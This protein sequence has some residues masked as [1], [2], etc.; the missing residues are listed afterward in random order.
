[1][2]QPAPN[3]G[4]RNNSYFESPTPFLVIRSAA[5]WLA[6]EALWNLHQ[7]RRAETLA[8]IQG[9]A[10]LADLHREEYALVSQM[11]RAA[12]ADL[13]LNLT[14]E[15]LQT[16]EWSDEQ[17]LGLQTCWEGK[18]FLETAEKA[19]V[20]ERLLSRETIKIKMSQEKD[21]S[22]R[23]FFSRFSNSYYGTNLLDADLLF[24]LRHVQGY[25]EQVRALRTNRAWNEVSDSLDQLN[26]RIDALTNSLQ[27]IRY[28][29][30][31]IAT[32]NFKPAVRKGVQ[33]ET[34]RRI[35]ITAIA[36]N[37]YEHK[38][39][40]YPASLD[41]LVPGLLPAIPRDCMN[42][43]PLGYQFK[44]MDAFILYSVGEDG[45]DNSGDPNPATN[46]GGKPGLWA[47]RD[48]VWPLPEN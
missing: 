20:G 39:G 33:T 4:Y 1:M 8:S 41:G 48:A 21:P 34:Q 40:Q 30:T 6:S 18:D 44:G 24:R 7:G 15:A 16:K 46:L 37:R 36:L 47:G 27:R 26:A 28:P 25:V 23:E 14:W 42:G 19:M 5:N 3:A 17:L 45:Q 2:K 43:Q 38:H 13:G 32:P 11:S 29:L 10:G 9:L 12:V 35:A 22:L 31:L